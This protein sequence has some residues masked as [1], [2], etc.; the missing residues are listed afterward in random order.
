MFQMS[1]CNSNLFH[2]GIVVLFFF[3]F[4]YLYQI[5][6]LCKYNNIDL[7]VAQKYSLNGK[8]AQMFY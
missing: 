7:D 3:F 1:D 8:A 6:K 4:N 5:G 2:L